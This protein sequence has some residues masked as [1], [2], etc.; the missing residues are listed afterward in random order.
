MMAYILGDLGNVAC[1]LGKYDQA[2][3]YF[4][5]CYTV[6]KEF[7][8][9][10]GMAV[11]LNNLAKIARLQQD[12]TEAGRLLQRSLALYQRINDRGGLAA[13]YYGLGENALARGD[14]AGAQ[15]Y[16]LEALQRAAQIAWRPMMLA[17]LTAV[18]ELL[19]QWGQLSLA[20]ELLSLSA[21]HA[22]AN[23]E[24]KD[25][26]AARL[27]GLAREMPPGVFQPSLENGKISEL[28]VVKG[29]IRTSQRAA[30]IG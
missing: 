18:A 26:A 12:H 15:K 7:N 14:L 2:R 8:D 16:L 4:Q 10:E 17:I 27:A 23:Q 6:K 29:A 30:G 20:V 5:T 1:A 28:D 19:R 9:P 24:T 22:A 21:I 3:Q 13:S 11:A 25:I